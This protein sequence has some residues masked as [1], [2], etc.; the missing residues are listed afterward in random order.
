MQNHQHKPRLIRRIDD[1]GYTTAEGYVP[2]NDAPCLKYHKVNGHMEP[3][4]RPERKPMASMQTV[5]SQVV[6]IN[7]R[8][9]VS[10]GHV[11]PAPFGE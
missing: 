6:T 11:L 5:H 10:S 2:F 7:A 9:F 8:Q 1:Y 3:V 4:P